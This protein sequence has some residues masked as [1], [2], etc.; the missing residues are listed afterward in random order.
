MWPAALAANG[1]VVRP[2]V[3]RRC[4]F[5]GSFAVDAAL[6]QVFELTEPAVIYHLP[7]AP[8]NCGK[9]FNCGP[10]ILKLPTVGRASRSGR[11]VRGTVMSQTLASKI[12]RL[13]PPSPKKT[14]QD[15]RGVTACDFSIDVTGTIWPVMTVYILW[16]LHHAVNR[17]AMKGEASL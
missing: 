12:L 8:G 5:D 6:T 17:R 13:P 2:N 14:K 3:A 4:S 11:A 10:T 15:C 16:S 1:E 7:G 9:R